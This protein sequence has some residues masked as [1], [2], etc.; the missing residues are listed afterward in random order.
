MKT[1]I[2]IFYLASIL[3]G[4]MTGVISCSSEAPFE[5]DGIGHVRM[6]VNV[7]YKVTRA[8]SVAVDETYLKDNCKIYITRVEGEEQKVVHKWVGVKNIPQDGV[9]LRY[10]SYIAQAFAGDLVGASFDKTYFKGEYLFSISQDKPSETI[11]LNCK[12][13]N[14]VTSVDQKAEENGQISD[15]SVQF[16]NSVASLTFEGETLDDK[17]YFMMPYKENVLNYVI[18]GKNI[19]GKDIEQKGQIKNVKQGHEYRL[20]LNAHPQDGTTGGALV[21]ITVEEINITDLEDFEIFGPPAFSWVG[22]GISIEDQLVNLENQFETRT[23]RIGAYNGFSKLNLRTA[24]PTLKSLF[25]GY[26]ELMLLGLDETQ[27]AQLAE[28]GVNVTKHDSVVNNLHKY[29][30]EFSADFFNNLPKS[31]DPYIMEVVVEDAKG[32]S[33]KMEISIAN[34]ESA[35]THKA[36]IKVEEDNIKSDLTAIKSTTAMIPVSVEADAENPSVQY[37]L[38]GSSSWTTVPVNVTRANSVVNL[39]GL[40]PAST[41]EY[42][43][44]AGEIENGQYSFVSDVYTFETEPI[45]IIPNSSFEEWGNYSA[46]TLFGTKTVIFPGSDRSD[47]FWDSGNEGAAT[48]N[49]VLTDKSEDMKHSGKYSVRLASASA[50]GVLAAGNVFTGYYVKTDGTNGVLSVGHEYDGSHPSKLRVYANYRPGGSVSIKKGNESFVEIQANGTDHGQIYVALTTG[51]VEIRTNP[52]NRKLFNKDDDEVIAYGEVTWKENFGPDGDLEMVEIPLEYNSKAKT[53][54]PTHLVI[55]CSASKFGDYFSGS[56][57]SV[58][59]L[60]DFELIYE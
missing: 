60:D 9:A 28:I 31:D 33:N 23:L 6:D 54:K 3:V 52:N 17:G 12:I 59:Y 55:V 38:S 56:A 58:M 5:S 24:N 13:A 22:M 49:K 7:N 43:V 57:S 15:L 4:L 50:V 46:S 10:G 11:L 30:I 45:F 44:V 1:T 18:T 8:E 26:G 41:Y 47:H 14:V 40:T 25:F 37:R 34:T 35:I 16:S 36:P 2:K 21:S 20:I 53:I 51:S 27:D 39:T 32:K 42:R 29:F 19:Q 48:A